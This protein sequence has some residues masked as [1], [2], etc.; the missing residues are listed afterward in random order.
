MAPF[1]QRNIPA[2][3]A[4]PAVGVGITLEDLVAGH[5]EEASLLEW[6]DASPELSLPQAVQ[7][8]WHHWTD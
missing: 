3:P 4:I 8:W 6:L 2:V 5:R 1:V 7:F